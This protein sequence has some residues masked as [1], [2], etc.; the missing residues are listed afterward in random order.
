MKRVRKAVSVALLG[1][2]LSMPVSV[3]AQR[4]PKLKIPYSVKCLGLYAFAPADFDVVQSHLPPGF[5]PVVPRQV[6]T[7]FPSGQG[8]EGAEAVV[9]LQGMTCSENWAAEQGISFGGLSTFVRRPGSR[10][11]DTMTTYAWK[12]LLSEENE[13]MRFSRHGL[14]VVGGAHGSWYEVEEW[15]LH[16]SSG[17]LKIEGAVEATYST[18]DAVTEQDISFELDQYQQAAKGLAIWRATHDVPFAYEG[19]VVLRSEADSFLAEL[20]GEE[21]IEARSLYSLSHRITGRV[22]IPR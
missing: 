5:V 15:G 12:V 10:P 22:I 21:T 8:F 9:M 4:K 7:I 13:R 1:A 6:R 14:D 16:S 19:T 11:G 17:E 20:M 2:L 18:R 3:E